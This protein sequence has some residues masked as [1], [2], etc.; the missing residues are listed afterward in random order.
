MD[1]L[2]AMGFDEI[3]SREALAAAGGNVDVA[4]EM[5]LGGTL[6]EQVLQ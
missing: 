5:I 4:L 3:S 1:S 2:L 6:P